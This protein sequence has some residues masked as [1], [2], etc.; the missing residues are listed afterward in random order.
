MGPHGNCGEIF[1]QQRDN[2]DAAVNGEDDGYLMTC[3][4]DWKQD[5]AQFVMWDAKT[6]K[7]VVRCNMK[8]RVPHGFHSYFV[9]E[10]D[11]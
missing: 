8:S 1:Y 11:Q 6:M 10:N 3:M 4:H 7:E 2:S 5:K 9:H